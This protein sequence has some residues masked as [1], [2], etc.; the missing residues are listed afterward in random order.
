MPIIEM[1]DCTVCT[2][3]LSS[4]RRLS[5]VAH[6]DEGV[7]PYKREFVSNRRTHIE[8]PLRP[9]AAAIAQHIDSVATYL[10]AN[11]KKTTPLLMIGLVEEF[12]I[13]L[14]NEIFQHCLM[15]P[16]ENAAI[17][18]LFRHCLDLQWLRNDLP[19]ERWNID[20]RNQ[21]YNG[22][23]YLH[24]V[25][26]LDKAQGLIIAQNSTPDLAP[27]ESA[28]FLILLKQTPQGQRY[29]YLPN[30]GIERSPFSED[31]R[32]RPRGFHLIPSNLG[33]IAGH[34][35]QSN[36]G[37][38]AECLAC[39]QK[40]SQTKLEQI[41]AFLVKIYEAQFNIKARLLILDL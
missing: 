22:I 32:R 3:R 27:L 40:A 13:G 35:V 39:F 29:V 18:R 36:K 9:L 1:A 21:Y 41:N 17:V 20:A 38:K 6:T 4:E 11:A 34:L 7:W 33:K 25:M 19:V 14:I 37:L 24:V 16:T 2:I 30:D 28:D 8:V 15:V 12:T 5:L 26:Y 23:N 10:E 31:E